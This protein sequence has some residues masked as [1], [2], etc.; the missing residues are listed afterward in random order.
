MVVRTRAHVWIYH[1]PR[2]NASEK[3]VET[4]AP[5]YNAPWFFFAY[6]WILP[7]YVPAIEKKKKTLHMTGDRGLTP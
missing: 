4:P 2:S 1:V 7:G 6:V 3:I 5:L